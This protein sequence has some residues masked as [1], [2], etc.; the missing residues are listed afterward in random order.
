MKILRKIACIG[1]IP[2]L[3]AG[4]FI[5]C[6]SWKDDDC[7]STSYTLWSTATNSYNFYSESYCK[8]TASDRGYKCYSY[9]S[10]NHRCYGYK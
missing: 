8:S 2:L 6:D 10:A 1:I 5:S 7:P 3:T 9:D 4:L